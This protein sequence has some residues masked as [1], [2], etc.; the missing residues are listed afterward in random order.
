VAQIEER[1]KSKLERG[2]RDGSSDG[3]HWPTQPRPAVHA[4]RADA[5]CVRV[6]A[7]HLEYLG[8]ASDGYR[9]TSYCEVCDGGAARKPM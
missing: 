2:L 7:L 3:E 5:R 1:R 8:R 9:Y 4:S 6:G